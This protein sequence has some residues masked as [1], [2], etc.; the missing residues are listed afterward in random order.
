VG[1]RVAGGTGSQVRV[2]IF[3]L[4]TQSI[5]S[6]SLV[7][8]TLD[9]ILPSCI[10]A[11]VRPTR[12]YLLDWCDIRG[13]WPNRTFALLGLT[14]L[15]APGPGCANLSDGWAVNLPSLPITIPLFSFFSGIRYCPGPGKSIVLLAN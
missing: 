8:L 4:G 10:E 6:A 5:A 12:T 13:D 3:V 14:Q 9:I 2:D 15:Y 7:E 1:G 11:K